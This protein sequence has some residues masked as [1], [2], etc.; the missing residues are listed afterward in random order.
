MT[1]GDIFRLLE[2]LHSVRSSAAFPIV[3]LH[4]TD[5]ESLGS[6]RQSPHPAY[7]SLFKVT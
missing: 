4:T 5:G 3:I 7:T 6:I 1:L 2:E